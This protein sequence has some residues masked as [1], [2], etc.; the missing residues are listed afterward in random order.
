MSKI[1]VFVACYNYGRFLPK[2]LNSILNQTRKTDEILVVDDA[3]TD[4]TPEIIKPYLGKVKYIRH[5]KNIGSQKMFNV[6]VTIA[7]GDYIL[8]ISAD[9]WLRPQMLEKEASILD[10]NPEVGLVYSQ[11]FTVEQ[12]QKRLIVARPAGKESYIGRKEDF[13]LLLTQGCFIPAMTVLVRKKVYDHLGSWDTKL[14]FSQD[15]EMW[16]RIAKHYALAYIA[17][18]LAYY[19]IHGKNL[20][21]IG[22]WKKS[23]DQENLYILRKHLPKNNA[24]KNLSLKEEAFYKYYIGIANSSFF[25]T[26]FKK[27]FKAWEKAI[28]LKHTNFLSY[29]IWQPFY[30]LLKGAMRKIIL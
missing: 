12:G 19:R 1:S 8:A 18:P 17:E 13:K 14:K 11:A 23:R 25:S 16:I 24:P 9:D 26:N 20:T 2:C 29:Q 28:S 3:S 27:G 10:R 21:L 5:K 6:G 15:Y 4:N 30:L 7:K 22:D